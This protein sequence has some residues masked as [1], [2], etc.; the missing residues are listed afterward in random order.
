MEEILFPGCNAYQ[1]RLY[2]S[3]IILISSSLNSKTKMFVNRWLKQTQA[4]SGKRG[5]SVQHLNF[6]VIDSL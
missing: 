3:C 6:E 1:Y 2:S 4:G 5:I